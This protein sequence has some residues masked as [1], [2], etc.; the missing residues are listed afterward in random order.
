MLGRLAVV[1]VCVSVGGCKSNDPGGGDLGG[2]DGP[3]SVPFTHDYFPYYAG[4]VWQFE[5]TT[6][7]V[8]T[9]TTTKGTLVLR[10]TAFD[11][12]EKVATVRSSSLDEGVGANGTVYLR[13]RAGVLERSDDKA[14]WTKLVN[15]VDL[16]DQD[17]GFL[18]NGAVEKPSKMFGSLKTSV[19]EA[20]ATTLVGGFPAL[21]ASREYVASGNDPYEY[22][23]EAHEDWSAT[24]GLVYAFRHYR[25]GAMG[26]PNVIAMKITHSLAGHLVNAP[27]PL[28]AG[29]L[30]ADDSAPA[31]P[32]KLAVERPGATEGK[33]SW[34][35][36]ALN[37]EAFLIE[38]K[39]GSGAFVE[40]GKVDW[41]ATS[42]TDGGLDAKTSYR[43]RVRARNKAGLSA[44]SDEVLMP[45]FGAP[46][47][48][49]LADARFQ[50]DTNTNAV[51]AYLYWWNPASETVAGFVV[52]YRKSGDAAWTE[53]AGLVAPDNEVINKQ[54]RT[55]VAIYWAG[56]V[57]APTYSVTS[58]SWPSGSYD[59]KVRAVRDGCD[60]AESKALTAAP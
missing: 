56:K 46:E 8:R 35:D 52:S 20:S 15:T 24:H 27:T 2:G 43:Y 14:T 44:A 40:V 51:Y 57:G 37:E 36:R 6:E 45:C 28:K 50:V 55:D 53:I 3:S 48:P 26:Y 13:K 29:S 34:N 38:R 4:S 25:D 23:H 11:E 47:A 49:D 30:P 42:F 18:L 31:A 21:E 9:N 1:V 7:N 59:F 12:N 58:T 54:R 41:D 10:V 32:D 19:K 17:P 16:K 39:S 60:S 5:K 22:A 33:L